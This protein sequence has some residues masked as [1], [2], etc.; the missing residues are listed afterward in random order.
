VTSIVVVGGGPAGL[1]VA[2]RARSRGLACTVLDK[3]DPPIDK[4]CGEGL[5][6]SGV[7]ALLRL[8]VTIAPEQSRRFRGLTLLHE[9]RGRLYRARSDFGGGR[10]GLGVR[11]TVLH[12]AM[13]DR[14]REVGVGLR[15]R[16]RVTGL[17][18]TTLQ[19]DQGPF[20]ADWVVAADGLRS[21]V[22]RWID[23]ERA[24][25]GR[26]RYGLRQHFR[27][28][29]WSDDVEVYWGPGCE[30]Y[31]TPVDNDHVGVALLCDGKP[32]TFEQLLQA[33]PSLR[34]RLDG[35]EP[36][37]T[38]RGAGPMRQIAA[39]G[40]RDRIALVGDAAGFVDPI[41]GEGVSL[42]LR[43]AEALVEAI[44]QGDLDRYRT[45]LRAIVRWPERITLLTLALQR[46]RWL[47]QATIQLLGA[48][49]L[50]YRAIVRKLSPV[51]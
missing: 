41:T 12:R 18:R 35:A 46:P 2:I 13:V 23:T 40:G 15:W 32:S 44:E 25:H 51:G 26:E 47:Q 22:R 48:A 29:P 28:S 5:M 6:P 50:L 16:T 27:V 3:A 34:Q 21:M 33:F 1:A 10:F 9:H 30:A 17:D 4:A 45:N 38:I 19:T 31:V 8:G 36:A 20:S 42:A 49:P 14:A 37:S 7:A 43:Q 11:R 24:A 39:A